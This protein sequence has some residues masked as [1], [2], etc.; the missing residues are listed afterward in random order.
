MTESVG[1]V[2]LGVM[3]SAIAVHIAAAGRWRVT[4]YDIDAAKPAALAGRGLIPVGSASALAETADVVVLSLPSVTAFDAVV[5]DL[6]GHARPGTAVVETSTLPLAAKL[7]GRDLLAAR[8]VVLLDCPLSGTG[9][10]A[11]DGDLVAYVSGA[12]PVPQV[13]LD[14]LAAFSRSQHLLGAFGNGTR[15]K[16]V[17]NL[18]VAIH[19]V[20]AAEALLLARRS[21]LDPEAVLA[22]V[23][24]GAGGSRMLQIRGPL[25]VDGRYEPATITNRLF[26]KDL[27]IIQA[28]ADGLDC[29]TPLFTAA[30][31]VYRAALAQGRDDQDTAA[32][33]AVLE[34]LTAPAADGHPR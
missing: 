6:A 16:L 30:A 20:A 4:G 23:G 14:V 1:V 33:Y 3:G 5:A 26:A 31:V 24:D 7:H 8:D 17:A 27:Q 25:M 15:M 10:Q 22:A 34:Q 9:Q 18:L 28:M 11:R 19:N 32:V 12:E 29:P 21:G 13:A 2:G